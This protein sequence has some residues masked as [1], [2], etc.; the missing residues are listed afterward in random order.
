MPTVCLSTAYLAPVSYYCQLM[1]NERV[2]IEQHENYIKQTYRNRAIIAT[3]NG[4]M[5]L[6]VPVEHC[7]GQ[8]IPIRDLRLSDHGNWRHLHWQAIQSAYDRSPFFEYYADDFRPF[9][10]G[11][12]TEFLLDFNMQLQQLICSLLNLDAS[13]VLTDAY[14]AEGDFVDLR[15]AITPKSRLASEDIAAATLRSYYQVFDQRHGF[16]A[17]LSIID[18]LFNMGPE[19]L[20][21]L[22]D[23]KP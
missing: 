13:P 23:S 17:D 14:H 9:Y 4:P 19:A 2:L 15:N 6:T 11:R 5:S 21:V 12:P 10:E 16:M 7:K 18:L 1:A 3:A 20:L 8:K 22:R